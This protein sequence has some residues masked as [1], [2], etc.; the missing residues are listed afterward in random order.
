[1]YFDNF[2]TIPYD[3]AGT[4][5]F[6]DV[7]NL[8]RRV[9]VRAKAKANTLL[10][11]TYDVRNGETPESLAH[12]LYDDSELHWVILMINDITDRFHGWPMSESQ[13]LQYLN[14]RY[15]DVDAIHHYEISQESGDTSVKINIGTSN[16]DYPTA[17]AITNYEH[18]QEVQDVKRK[19]RL[20][21]PTYINQFLSEY[22]SLMQESNI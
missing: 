4:G 5:E 10:F 9:G 21:D 2:P 17:T 12:K 6:K 15:D 19:I 16:T 14:D 18:E 22:Q 13:F 20:L 1:M 7:K 8:L 11:D 3:S